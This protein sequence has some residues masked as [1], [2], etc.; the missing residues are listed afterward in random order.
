[1]ELVSDTSENGSPGSN[2]SSFLQSPNSACLSVIATPPRALASPGLAFATPQAA[3]PGNATSQAAAPNIYHTAAQALACVRQTLTVSDDT[4]D[5]NVWVSQ[6]LK[7]F[8]NLFCPQQ[9]GP[10]VRLSNADWFNHEHF[11][12]LF[13]WLVEVHGAEKLQPPT[14]F[15]AFQLVERY[16]LWRQNNNSPVVNEFKQ[17]VAVTSL[18]IASKVHDPIHCTQEDCEDFCDKQYNI[19]TINAMEREMLHALGWRLDRFPTPCTFLECFGA[20]DNGFLLCHAVAAGYALQADDVVT[21]DQKQLY[22]LACYLTE[23]ASQHAGT[24]AIVPSLLVCSCIFF[25]ALL[26]DEQARIKDEEPLESWAACRW[27]EHWRDSTG[28]SV[29]HMSPC[30]LALSAQNGV[31]HSAC[32][33]DNLWTATRT[34]FSQPEMQHVAVEFGNYGTDATIFAVMEA[35]LMM[36]VW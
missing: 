20:V 10:V 22:C 4:A 26:K 7:E 27:P 25:A 23:L 16:V 2:N 32:S 12:T 1:M 33:P 35:R 11:Q 15:L 13:D 17:L 5:I 24:R 28:Y 36:M 3:V 21:D 31:L 34:K 6:R 8:S 18:L 29:H 9:Q 14:L 30:I 19:P